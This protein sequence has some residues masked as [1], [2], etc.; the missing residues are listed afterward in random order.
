MHTKSKSFHLLK[1]QYF[2]LYQKIKPPPPAGS[3]GFRIG[4]RYENILLLSQYYFS[5][6]LCGVH[7]T[8]CTGFKLFWRAVRQPL[9]QYT[10]TCDAVMFHKSLVQLPGNMAAHIR[11]KAVFFRSAEAPPMPRPKAEAVLR[12]SRGHE[13]PLSSSRALKTDSAQ[14]SLSRLNRIPV[15]CSTRSGKS[16]VNIT[17]V[18][19][20][21][22]AIMIPGRFLEES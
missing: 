6:Y 3:R 4:L 22:F 20:F 14:L 9:V 5:G 19:P 12:S 10:A 15:F 1:I 18:L 13:L 8:L 17:A 2:V 21:K 7:S 11:A 16:L